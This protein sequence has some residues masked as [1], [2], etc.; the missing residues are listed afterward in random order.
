VQSAI[1]YSPFFL[2]H[3]APN[4]HPENPQR[5][6]AILEAF[7]KSA[8]SKNIETIEP[9][10]ASKE[11]IALNHSVKY[12]EELESFCKAGGGYLDDTYANEYS[13]ISAALAAGAGI[14]TVDMIIDNKISKGFCLVRPP[15]H[16]AEHD[17]A[18]G[19][20]LFNNAAITAKYALSKGFKKILLLDFDAHHGNG[21]QNSFYY[22]DQVLYISY[23]QWPHYPGTGSAEEKGEGDGLDYTI[24]IPLETGSGNKEF[25]ELFDKIVQPA[26][27]KYQPDLI[28]VSG[29]FDSHKDDPLAQLNLTDDG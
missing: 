5:L 4:Y 25:L 6:E 26:A 20:C 22:T 10:P 23:H 3:Q 7:K 17:K 18:M 28:I 16:H 19:F 8:F 2:K 13:Y 15:G 14:N 9:K 12:I 11:Q 27:D 1:L 29:G 21:T 24:N